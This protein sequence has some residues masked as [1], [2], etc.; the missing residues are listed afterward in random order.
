MTQ[1]QASVGGQAPEPRQSQVDPHTG[2]TT[3]RGGSGYDWTKY[4][5]PYPP[6]SHRHGSSPAMLRADVPEL[7]VRTIHVKARDPAIV[8]TFEGRAIPSDAFVELPIS[9]NLMQAVRSGD[10]EI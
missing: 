3:L 9:A 2:R 1:I 5:T 6:P 8:Y 4:N 10:L 7:P